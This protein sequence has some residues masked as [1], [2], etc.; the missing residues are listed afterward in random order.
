MIAIIDYKMGN[1]GSIQ[2]MLKK[3]GARSEI[4]DN[5]DSILAADKIILPGVGNFDHGVKKLRKHGMTS[6]LEK[7]VLENATPLLGICL[8]MQLL[9]EGSDEGS[10]AG[11]GWIRGK[12]LEFNFSK[13]NIKQSKIPHMG[14][15]SVEI[16][17]E[18]RLLEHLNTE[19][20]RFYFVHKYRVQCD[21]R[22]DVLATSHYGITFDSIINKKNIYG[23]QFHPEK[24]HKFG[25]QLLRNFLEL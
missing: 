16:Q 7:K 9:T 22:A 3:L 4:T 15:N 13:M 12:A 14:W 17:N 10:E 1:V 8:G 2:N 19:D 18:N 21:H 23:T 20:T 6:I 24:S 11:L 5:P 25:L